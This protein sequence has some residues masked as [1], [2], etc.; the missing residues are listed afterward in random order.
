[1]KFRL[2]FAIASILIVSVIST[3]AQSNEANWTRYESDDGSFSALLPPGLMVDA[4]K[5]DFGLLFRVFGF[6]KDVHIMLMGIRGSREEPTVSGEK[7]KTFRIGQYVVSISE[8]TIYG[9]YYVALSIF[10]RTGTF[11][12]SIEGPAANDPDLV[13]T[14]FGLRIDGKA[15]LKQEKPESDD[16]GKFRFSQLKTSPEIEAARERKLIKTKSEVT[17]EAATSGDFQKSRLDLTRPAIIVD[18][19]SADLDNFVRN[20]AVTRRGSTGYKYI[21]ATAR[22]TLRADG[23]VGNVVIV[24]VPK[25]DL[26]NNIIESARKIRFVPAQKDGVNVDSERIVQ[27]SYVVADFSQ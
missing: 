13:R 5:Q 1:M 19:P 10:G 2:L 14:L 26:A 15:L 6:S 27:Y 8:R 24:G 16:T 17:Y 23:Q 22:V 7:G 9:R 11:L 3:L 18:Q 21:N 20:S 25:G 12:L 4:K